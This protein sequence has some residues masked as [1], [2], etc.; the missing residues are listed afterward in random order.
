[1]NYNDLEYVKNIRK[2]E[3]DISPV[4]L[5]RWSPRSMRGEAMGSGELMSLFEAAKWA[6]SSFNE[7]PWRFLYA[8]KDSDSWKTFFDLMGEFNQTWTKNAA[9]LVLVIS[10]NNF[11]HND[12]PNAN[13]SFDAG[14]AWQN[15]ALEAS[16]RG[17][18]AHAM[19]GFDA[20]KAR[21]DLKVP[22]TYSIDAMI[23]IGKPG[24]KEDLPE[25][26]QA[27]E[28]PSSRK[29]IAE[30]VKEGVFSFEN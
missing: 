15:L 17:L 3:N 27:G 30:I 20:A 9:A 4:L 21:V 28:V 10:R 12:N 5:K 11:T 13:H 14:S 18:V 29:Q 24:K 6:P 16:E 7:Q 19:A 8:V 26:M 22:D 25:A 23:A 1:M 2:T